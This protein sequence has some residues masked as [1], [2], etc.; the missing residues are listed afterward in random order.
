M[1]GTEEDWKLLLTKLNN[2]K[3]LL[4]PVEV[5]LNLEKY[6]KN[7][8]DIFDNLLATFQGK[9]TSKWYDNF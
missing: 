9:D 5:S 4:K 2:V 6:F 1:L 8:E 3:K 7:V